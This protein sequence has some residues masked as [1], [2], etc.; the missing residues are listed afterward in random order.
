[1]TIKQVKVDKIRALRHMV[2]RPEQP[3]ESTDYDRDMDEQS[4]HYAALCENTIASIATFYPEKFP[5]IKHTLSYR[6]RGMA[7]H[8]KYR[9]KGFARQLMRHALKDLEQKR[10]DLLWCKARLVAL[11]F[12]ESLGFIKV[13]SI[14]EIDGIGPHYLMYKKI[15]NG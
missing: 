15:E 1:M 3:I 7:T 12:Y 8:P 5:E 4:L 2:L 9:R 10:C 11:S 13:G 6:L 14:F